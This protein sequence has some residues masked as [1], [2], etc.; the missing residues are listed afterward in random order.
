MTEKIN[1]VVKSVSEQTRDKVNI[2]LTDT[3]GNDEF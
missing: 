1:V 3:R 2:V